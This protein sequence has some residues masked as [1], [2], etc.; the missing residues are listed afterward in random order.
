MGGSTKEVKESKAYSNFLKHIQEA[1][2]VMFHHLLHVGREIGPVIGELAGI[3]KHLI[4]EIGYWATNVYGN[5]YSSCMPIEPLLKMAGFAG[6]QLHWSHR[7]GCE[8]SDSLQKLIWP[9][10]D[11]IY[12]VL[13]KTEEGKK[14]TARTFLYTLKKLR[15]VLLQDVACLIIKH[16][17]SWWEDQL[18]FNTPAFK[19]FLKQMELHMEIIENAETNS[20]AFK[21]TAPAITD[22][23]V[24]VQSSVVEEVKKIGSS[25]KQEFHVIKDDVSK[26]S[27]F[28][29]HMTSFRFSKTCEASIS[30]ISCDV[31]EEVPKNEAK[32]ENFKIPFTLLSLN[33]L[34]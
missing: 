16:G 34:K 22:A 3:A 2:D 11:G 30:S 1:C 18:P 20:S 14:S 23:L 9:E 10:I 8:P 15:V 24:R 12:E 32:T 4:E 28:I 26:T 17:S 31:T 5:V 21:K 19:E 27:S 6:L 33:E 7:V 29:D 13:L 25:M